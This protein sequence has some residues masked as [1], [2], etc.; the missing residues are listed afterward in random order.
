MSE[1]VSVSG[2]PTKPEIIAVSLSKLGLRDGDRFADIGC[3][4][5]SVSIEAA[6]IT[7]NL[8]IYAIDARKEALRATE[9]NFKNFNIENA[10]VLAGEASDILGSGDF[11]DF[12]DCAFVGGTKNIGSVLEILVKK[13]ARSIVVNAVRIET[14]VRTIESMKRLGIFDEVVHISVSRSAP[15]AGE[16]MFKPENPVYIVVGKTQN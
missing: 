13:K 6:R 2:G 16:T 1:I 3:G 5:G 14:V 10:R 8:T 15:I 12:I 9:T 4:T 11:V 7:R